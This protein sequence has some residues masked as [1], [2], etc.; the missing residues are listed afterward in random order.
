MRDNML[1]YYFILQNISVLFQKIILHFVCYYFILLLHMFFLLCV[2][3]ER[4][5]GKM[6]ALGPGRVTEVRTTV[7]FVSGS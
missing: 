5:A 3:G 7:E 4:M 1:F 6:S 2:E